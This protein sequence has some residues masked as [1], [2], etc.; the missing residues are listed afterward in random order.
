VHDIDCCGQHDHEKNQRK[1][2]QR[3]QYSH[4]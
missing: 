1:E 3:E 4:K 2:F